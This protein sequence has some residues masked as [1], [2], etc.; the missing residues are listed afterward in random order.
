MTVFSAGMISSHTAISCKVVRGV[1]VD[2]PSYLF[3]P[4]WRSR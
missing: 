3:A 1:S 2:Q 4:A